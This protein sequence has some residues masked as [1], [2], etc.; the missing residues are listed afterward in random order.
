MG[1]GVFRR[2]TRAVPARAT[3][4]RLF[5]T[6]PTPA[7]T[8]SLTAPVARTIFQRDSTGRADIIITGT[9]TGAPANIEASWQGGAYS[10]IN[11]SPTGGNFVGKLPLQAVGSGTLSVR[12]SNSPGV[13]TTASNIG[14]GD[15]Y[16]IAG[17]SNAGGRGTNNQVY[18]GTAGWGSLFGNDYVWKA[19]ADPTDSPGAGAVDTVSDEVTQGVSAAAGSVWPLVG[20]F[21]VGTGRVP[22]AFI[23]CALGGAAIDSWLP[24]GTG[25]YDRATLYGSMAYR[26]RN[27]GSHGVK[28]VLWWQGETDAINTMAQAS[29]FTKFQT[30]AAAVWLDLGVK[31]VPCK[32]QNSSAIPD[33]DEARI[34][35]A[36]G[37]AWEQDQNTYTGPSFTDIGSDDAYHLQTD[38]HLLTAAGRWWTVLQALFYQQ[39]RGLRASYLA[40]L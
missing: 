32:L 22:V 15:V 8:I 4:R 27:C 24:G 37:Q 40:G 26:A 3:R 21:V 5:V 36:I 9:Y 28:A 33:V 19:L 10:T 13:V 7:G 29:Y 12:F 20:N 6:A 34:N 39:T 35:A 14:V 16:V 1:T 30:F 23:P 2:K 38:P 11:S 17:Q 25:H 18:T 31:V